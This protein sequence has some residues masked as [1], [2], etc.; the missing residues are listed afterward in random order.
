MRA[1]PCPFPLTFH[2]RPTEHQLDIEDGRWPGLLSDSDFLKQAFSVR[3][4]MF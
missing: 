1:S 2:S 4:K 3:T